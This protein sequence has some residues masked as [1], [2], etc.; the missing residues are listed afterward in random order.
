MKLQKT[1]W[2]K[3]Y[4]SAEE[5]LLGMLHAKHIDA[6]RWTAGEGE[7]FAPHYHALDKR[8]WCAEGSIVFTIGGTK[9]SL[10]AGDALALP[11]NTTHRATAGISGAVCYE[12][13]RTDDNPIIEI[14]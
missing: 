1:R 9:I 4:E 12:F 2:S 6:E 10:Q 14:S 11:A 5:E 3:V 7:Y 8:I 13:P